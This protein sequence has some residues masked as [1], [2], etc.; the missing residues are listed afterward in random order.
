MSARDACAS[1]ASTEAGLAFDAGVMAVLACVYGNQPLGPCGIS[2]SRI[3]E[4]HA[5]RV[6]DLRKLVNGRKA[7]TSTPPKKRGAR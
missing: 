7:Y 1:A 5:Q 6:R 4:E 3:G 2:P